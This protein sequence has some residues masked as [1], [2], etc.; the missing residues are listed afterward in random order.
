M[1][2]G[3]KKGRITEQ[4]QS[5]P[6]LSSLSAEYRNRWRT[7]ESAYG[8]GKPWAI[9][10]FVA[11]QFKQYPLFRRALF[12]FS[13]DLIYRIK[14]VQIIVTLDRSSRGI[15]SSSIERAARETAGQRDIC[16]MGN[17]K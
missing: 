7:D 8:F 15:T 13:V 1:E 17:E 11:V 10:I 12:G 14:E 9:P 3:Q 5:A 4:E 2:E 16:I 6:V